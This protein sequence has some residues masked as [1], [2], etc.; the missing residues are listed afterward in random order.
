MKISGA[1]A[2]V[3]P[4]TA[5]LFALAGL[6]IAALADSDQ[7]S[8][9]QLSSPSVETVR[10][11]PRSQ[12]FMPNSAEDNAIQQRLSI[13]NEQQGLEDLALDKK[14]KICRGC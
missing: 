1:T 11:Q 14:L 5:L 13:F 4:S 10:V 12:E 3:V 7:P 2:C 6:P 8:P 9:K